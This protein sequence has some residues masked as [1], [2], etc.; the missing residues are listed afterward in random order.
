MPH[1]IK[2]FPKIQ[3]ENREIR[4]GKPGTVHMTKI[5]LKSNIFP[6]FLLWEL[7]FIFSKYSAHTIVYICY[8]TS[9]HFMPSLINNLK[10]THSVRWPSAIQEFWTSTLRSN[11][12]FTDLSNVLYVSNE[13]ARSFWQYC[14]LSSTTLHRQT[15]PLISLNDCIQWNPSE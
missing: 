15:L 12:E 4:A 14:I 11:S 1:T 9:L 3:F 6:L 2:L 7:I 13:A 10:K 8:I 5:N